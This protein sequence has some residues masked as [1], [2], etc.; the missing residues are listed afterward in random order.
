MEKYEIAFI[1]K[2]E[3]RVGRERILGLI[4]TQRE[5][6]SGKHPIYTI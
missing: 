1:L 6:E 4:D 5:N 3:E 2:N